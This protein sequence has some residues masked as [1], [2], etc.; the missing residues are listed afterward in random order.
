[1]LKDNLL[2]DSIVNDANED[3]DVA[4]AIIRDPQS[5]LLTSQFSSFNYH[6]AEVRAGIAAMPKESSFED[7]IRT[8]RKCATVIEISVPVMVDIETVG[9]VTI[10]MSRGAVTK[11]LMKTV[12]AVVALN[13]A[14]AFVLGAA[15]FIA[16]KRV[17]LNPVSRLADTAS[18]LARGEIATLIDMKT[19]GEVKMLVDSFNQMA[20]NLD[21]TTVSKD[22]VNSIINSM[23]DSL[24]VVAPDGMIVSVN[25]AACK[26]LGYKEDELLGRRIEMIFEIGQDSSDRIMGE[27]TVKGFLNNT[28]TRCRAKNGAAIT[29][30]FSVLQYLVK[31]DFKAWFW[32]QGCH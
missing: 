6:S 19:S 15:L 32:C 10:G 3:D 22:Y 30:I 1:M 7:M 25:A 8:V 13:I 16:T 14:V 2:L 9:A 20:L 21:N 27:I 12:M 31:A 23:L 4:Y 26:V 28:E 5:N 24:L 17:I 29:M 11:E 18:S